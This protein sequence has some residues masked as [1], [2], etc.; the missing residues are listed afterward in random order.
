MRCQ[1]HGKSARP[2]L[3]IAGIIDRD[4]DRDAGIVDDDVQAAELSGDIVDDDRD[5]IAVGDVEPPGSRASPAGRDLACDCLGTL[6]I[7]I[8]DGDICAL[9]GE[10]ARGG[11][12]HAG[13]STRDEHGQS[14]HRTAERF[15]IKHFA[16]RGKCG[17]E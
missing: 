2:G 5:R 16:A 1:H 10:H 9:V 11:A 17:V 15:E 13:R 3:V 7:E 12:P 6:A 4:A 8:R 14:F